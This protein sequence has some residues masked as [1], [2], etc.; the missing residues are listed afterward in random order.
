MGTRYLVYNK[1]Q[2]QTRC[3]RHG[4]GKQ[5]LGGREAGLSTLD[6]HAHISTVIAHRH[7]L[8]LLLLYLRFGIG[9]GLDFGEQF[10]K[11][12]SKSRDWAQKRK[13]N[14]NS[15]SRAYYCPDTSY[16]YYS[17]IQNPKVGYFFPNTKIDLPRFF[18]FWRP[19]RYAVRLDR[20]PSSYD[21]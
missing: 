18:R 6:I 15:K 10:S 9:F 3:A 20:T 19:R 13:L 7:Q 14:E 17:K 2:I 12:N 8:L 11:C 21:R 5:S 16:I 1:L 4:R